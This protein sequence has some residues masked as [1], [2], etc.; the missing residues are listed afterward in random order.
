MLR[1]SLIQTNA[2]LVQTAQKA[3]SSN[4]VTYNIKDLI[5]DPTRNGDPV[6]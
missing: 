2:A 3:F 1:K 5:F 4:S 6:Y